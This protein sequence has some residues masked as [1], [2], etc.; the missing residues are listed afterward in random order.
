MR[1]GGGEGEGVAVCF[2]VM[3]WLVPFYR[4]A[5]HPFIGRDAYTCVLGYADAS[6]VVGYV[7]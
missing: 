2:Q 4:P 6:R 1:C 5:P 3:E 7:L